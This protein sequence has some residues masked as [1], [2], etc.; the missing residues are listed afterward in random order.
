MNDEILIYNGSGIKSLDNGKVGGYLVMFGG[1]DL[2]GDFFTKS[3]DFGT[4]TKT[5][6]WFN[7]R[8]PLETKGGDLLTIKQKI[9][10]GE[11]TIDDTGVFLEAVL[12]NREQ[13]DQMLDSLGW[14]SG[15]AAHLVERKSSGE[16]T[17]WPL[18]LDA[19]LTP[20]PAEPRTRAVSLKSLTIPEPQPGGEPGAMDENI[21]TNEQL[22]EENTQIMT[23]ELK[24]VENQP[25]PEAI[26]YGKIGAMLNDAIEAKFNEPAEQKPAAKAVNVI[27]KDE[28]SYADAFKSYLHTKPAAKALEAGTTTE[29]GYIVPEDWIAEMVK[30]LTEG[31]ILRTA[32]AR[33]IT[34]NTDKVYFPALTNSTAA[35]LTAEEGAYSEVD[36]AF[37]QLS[38]TPYKYT[39]L[40]K[41]T[42]ELAADSMFDI[43]GQVLAP[44]FS[45]AFVLAENA[46]FTTGTGSSQPQGVV[47]GSA[48]G[49]TAASASA[50]T[51]DEV[52]DLYHSLSYLYRQNAVWMMN[53]STI[54]AVRKLKDGD[55]QYLWQPGLQAGQPDMLLGRPVITNNSMDAIATGNKTIVFGD[56]SYYWITER[57]GLSVDVNPW[58]YMANGFIGYFARKRFDAKVALSAAIKHLI[59]A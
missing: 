6:V 38:F 22:T 13:Y 42:E 24:N 32:G 58:L 14:S 51:A 10:D 35:V 55:S 50:I 45:N 53:D 20:I 5:D 39:K 3:T 48:L 11:I 18:G 16:I 8:Q 7:H 12:Y 17:H 59:Q 40:T 28:M 46:A 23:D 27:V 2:Q 52:I 36:P 49:K 44:D 21:N 33:I 25:A 31:S 41:V 57:A 56:M 54:A 4:A 29:G 1:E 15:T 47:T 34:I 30:P 19:S 43:W 26:D 37:T 9:G